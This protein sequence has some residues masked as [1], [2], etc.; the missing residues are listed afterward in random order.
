MG[1]RAASAAWASGE[2]SALA[3]AAAKHPVGGRQ[4]SKCFWGQMLCGGR[5]KALECVANKLRSA[6]S[7]LV[8]VDA[9]P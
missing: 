1:G 9:V 3:G 5:E 6:T 7:V 8:G 2:G 4:R